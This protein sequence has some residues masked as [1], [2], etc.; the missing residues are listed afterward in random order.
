M[1]LRVALDYGIRVV[2]RDGN[3]LVSAGV[4]RQLGRPQ[5]LVVFRGL[6]FQNV[7]GV[8]TV[9]QQRLTAQLLVSRLVGRCMVREEVECLQPSWFCEVRSIGVC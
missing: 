4:P 7:S 2:R 8:K 6:T 1:K 9:H 3:T 5:D